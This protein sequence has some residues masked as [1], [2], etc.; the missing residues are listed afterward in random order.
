M[1]NLI[2]L[3]IYYSFFYMICNDFTIE[4]LLPSRSVQEVNQNNNILYTYTYLKTLTNNLG[5]FPLD[6]GP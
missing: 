2:I 5:C 3:S 4:W 6:F 1:S